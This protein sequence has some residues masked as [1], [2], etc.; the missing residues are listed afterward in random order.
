M[1]G[2]SVPNDSSATTMKLSIPTLRVRH[3]CCFP[4]FPIQNLSVN[5][6]IKVNYKHMETPKNSLKV[7]Y[8]HLDGIQVLDSFLI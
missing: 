3:L 8:F 1:S 6:F 5:A 7:I 4:V 2:S